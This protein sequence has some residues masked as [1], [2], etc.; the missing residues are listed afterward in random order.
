MLQSVIKSIREGG[1]ST[2][3]VMPNLSPPIET[4][5]QA[6]AYHAE[7]TALEPQVEYL[8]S[9]YLSKN[10]TP[11]TVRKARRSGKIYG[12]KMYPQG[13]TTGSESGVVSLEPFY[14][15]FR[16]MQ[17][18]GLVLNL[19]GEEPSGHSVD[20]M[21][22]ES[23]F[24]PQLQILNNF[25]PKLKIVL[26]HCT[27][28]EAIIAVLECN[29]SVAGTITAHHLFLTQSDV[30]GDPWHFC[31]PVAKTAEDRRALLQ[32][33]TTGNPK[34]F[35]GSDSAPHP[36]SA[37]SSVNGKKPAAG[38]FTAPV[39]TQLVLQAVERGDLP[40]EQLS[41]SNITEFLSDNGR[42][43]YELGPPEEYL[44]L[45][46][47]AAVIPKTV[48]QQGSDTEVA[49]FKAGQKTWGLEWVAR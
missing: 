2:V 40:R 14:P 33:A 36:L 7:L 27:T 49:V 3:F 42:Y 23:L 32:A 19:H 31:K 44:R 43:F 35:F 12:I 26:E 8:M 24:L 47:D 39:A 4:V 29:R 1:C 45:T 30:L 18:E 13:V 20:M 34:F 41:L 15:V 17:K 5:E 11:D 38:V 28:A 46:R 22:A 48:G 9:L 25:F 21:N 6:E 10:I 37:K 16:A